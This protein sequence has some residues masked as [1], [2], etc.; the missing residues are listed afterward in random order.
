MPKLKKKA[1]K[2]PKTVKQYVFEL[3]KVKNR[4][5]EKKKKERGE[6]L[7]AIISLI[8]DEYGK[9]RAKD[10]NMWSEHEGYA[11]LAEEL[12]RLWTETKKDRRVRDVKKFRK[13]AARIAATAI[14]IAAN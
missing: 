3:D 5:A 2:T 14:F 10:E 7:A 9:M 12:D 8:L 13:A 4:R 6:R 11:M 1:P